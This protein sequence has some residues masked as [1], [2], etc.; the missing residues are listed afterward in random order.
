MGTSTESNH[1]N[2]EMMPMLSGIDRFKAKSGHPFRPMPERVSATL[3]QIDSAFLETPRKKG[4]EWRIK[5]A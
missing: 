3:D 2:H 1:S 4:S 5:A